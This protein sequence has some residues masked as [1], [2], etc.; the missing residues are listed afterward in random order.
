MARA[1][2]TRARREQRARSAGLA[3]PAPIVRKLPTIDVIDEE[4]LQRLEDQADWLIQ[5]IGIE[6]RQDP[7]ALRIWREAG[8][9]VQETRVRL[10]KGMARALCKT[11][12]A[13]FTQQARNPARSVVIGGDNVV[14]APVYGPRSRL[15]SRVATALLWA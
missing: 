13:Q 14:F 12:P 2:A 7:E 15:C 6:F 11:A 9:D 10:P 8:A 4:Q 5:E 1:S 3:A